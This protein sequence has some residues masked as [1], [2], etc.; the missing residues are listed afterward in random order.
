MIRSFDNTLGFRPWNWISHNRR[1]SKTVSSIVKFRILNLFVL[2]FD[3]IDSFLYLSY[4][5]RDSVLYRIINSSWPTSRSVRSRPSLHHLLPPSSPCHFGRV[6]RGTSD[7]RLTRNKILV[8]YWV[9][10]RWYWSQY[11]FDK[12]RVSCMLSWSLTLLKPSYSD[13]SV[14]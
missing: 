10:V 11:S 4:T 3:T 5:F 14:G 12:P 7:R 1:V 8:W 9:S 6:R 13:D 2:F